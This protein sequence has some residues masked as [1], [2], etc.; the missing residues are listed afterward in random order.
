MTG[1]KAMCSG[2]DGIS[3]SA[4]MSAASMSSS[5]NSFSMLM[6]SSSMSFTASRLDGG[7]S[8]SIECVRRD[9]L[10]VG[11]SVDD[12]LSRASSS[13]TLLRATLREE[14]DGLRLRLIELDM[15]DREN[16]EEAVEVLR[17]CEET[18]SGTLGDSM[19][20]RADIGEMLSLPSAR[21]FR[22]RSSRVRSVRYGS[23]RTARR[24]RAP[25]VS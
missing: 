25:V 3:K 22:R 6:I 16:T 15:D 18:S 8:L 24:W 9:A 14:V 7:A 21:C 20:L 19:R 23:A 11:R 5:S 12:K 17:E 4:W 1:L 2:V 13:M 10:R